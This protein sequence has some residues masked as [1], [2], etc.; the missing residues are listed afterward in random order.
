MVWLTSHLLWLSLKYFLIR[1]F[2]SSSPYSSR[3]NM[4]TTQTADCAKLGL[5]WHFY[6]Q[7]LRLN[8]IQGKKHDIIRY[9]LDAR[10]QNV[11]RYSYHNCEFIEPAQLKC[12]ILQDVPW[13]EEHLYPQHVLPRRL[14]KATTASIVCSCKTQC[15][16]QSALVHV[17]HRKNQNVL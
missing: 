17:K 16:K 3:W 13:P 6:M 15:H 2:F 14:G 5:L 11:I 1:Y 7:G 8:M 10:A 4:K 9:C 12:D